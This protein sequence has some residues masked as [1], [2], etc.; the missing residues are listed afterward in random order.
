MDACVLR[1][2][3]VCRTVDVTDVRGD[4][5]FGRVPSIP[6]IDKN[7]SLCLNCANNVVCTDYLPAFWKSGIL[8]PAK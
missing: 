7:G 5:A 3:E 2:C 4:V 8:V 1:E 6:R